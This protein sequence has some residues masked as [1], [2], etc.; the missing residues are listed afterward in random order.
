MKMVMKENNGNNSQFESQYVNG[1]VIMAKMCNVVEEMAIMVMAIMCS[2]Y[3]ACNNNL[4]GV[5]CNVYV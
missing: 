5:V 4:C 3:V 2:S 1:Y